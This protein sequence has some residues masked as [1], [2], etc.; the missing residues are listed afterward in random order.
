[1]FWNNFVLL[2]NKKNISPNGACAALGLSVATATKWKKGAVPRDTTLQKIADYFGVSTEYLLSDNEEKPN[3]AHTFISYSNE[4]S[5]ARKLD[6]TLFGNA[7]AK[8]MQMEE[9][10]ELEDDLWQN[11]EK[12]LAGQSL[13][14]E[15]YQ[16]ISELVETFRRTPAESR[17]ALLETLRIMIKLRGI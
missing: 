15:S 12:L 17:P 16:V 4:D 2:C 7:P 5:S 13:N 6:L 14:K 9:A 1:M 11:I 8:P 10:S 3:T